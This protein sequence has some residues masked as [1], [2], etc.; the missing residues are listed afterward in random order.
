MPARRVGTLL[1]VLA[2]VGALGV[3]V[4]GVLVYLVGTTAVASGKARSD[5]ITLLDSVRT[6]A[7]DAQAALKTLPPFDLS[8]TNPDFARARQTADQYGSQLGGYRT[9][10]QGDEVKLRSDRDRLT[11]RAT[12]VLALPFRASL[13]HERQRAEGLLF[14]LQAEDTALQ[15]EQDQMRAISAIFDAEGDFYVLLVN[16]VGKQDITGSL[17]LFPPLDGKLKT[18]AQVAAGPSTPPQL[19]KLVVSM[20]TLSTDLNAFLRA[21]QRRDQRTVQALQPKVDAD[22]TALDN[23]DSVSLDA[24]ERTLLQPYLD[25]FDSGV[26]AAGFT[27]KTV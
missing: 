26:R 6:R 5:S 12:G 17:A 20:Q 23:F 16:H 24:Y 25:R 9:T 11:S 14:A 27:P 4:A 2:V 7:N 13:D 21:A 8:S 3:I 19:Q 15:I 22:A 10:V 18:A 1:K